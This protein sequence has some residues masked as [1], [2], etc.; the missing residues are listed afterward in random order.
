[1]PCFA[2]NSAIMLRFQSSG[3][4]IEFTGLRADLRSR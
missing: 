2:W 3:I 4:A 1:L